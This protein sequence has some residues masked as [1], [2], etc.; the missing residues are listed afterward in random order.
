MSKNH[1]NDF[2]T[3]IYIKTLRKDPRLLRVSKK[4]QM[5][6]VF[7]EL[8]PTVL[9]FVLQIYLKTAQIIL[10][11][12]HDSQISGSIPAFGIYA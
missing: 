10:V 12:V 4:Q 2:Q 11:V 8:S 1:P 5:H 3:Q 7:V 9:Q 6:A